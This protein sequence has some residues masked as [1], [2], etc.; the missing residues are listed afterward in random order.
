M[1]EHASLQKCLFSLTLQRSSDHVRGPGDFFCSAQGARFTAIDRKSI[2]NTAGATHPCAK[3]IYASGNL[4]STTD[5]LK[6][7]W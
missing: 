6:S 2:T 4:V 7:V 3:L 5:S 1:G